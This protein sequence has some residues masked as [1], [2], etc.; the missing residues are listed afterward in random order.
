MVRDTQHELIRQVARA[1]V[2]LQRLVRTDVH[3]MLRCILQGLA[4]RAHVLQAHVQALAGERMRRVRRVADKHGAAL[5]TPARGAARRQGQRRERRCERRRERAWVLQTAADVAASMLE[6]QRETRDATRVDGIAPGRHRPGKGAGRR[7]ALLI[8]RHDAQDALLQRRGRRR[9]H[10]VQDRLEERPWQTERS[11]YERRKHARRA[12]CMHGRGSMHRHDRITQLGRQ[13][14]H[15]RAGGRRERE[16]REGACR[17]EPLPCHRVD[18]RLR[19]AR[20]QTRAQRRHEAL[21]S[22]GPSVALYAR[23]GP[24]RRA[25]AIRAHQQ[26]RAHHMLARLVLKRNAGPVVGRISLDACDFR[27]A[28]QREAH[29]AVR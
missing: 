12:V 1:F 20:V 17:H 3:A 19:A 11:R 14:P 21:A 24:H 5:S 25:R 27:G 18:H 6:L 10:G 23:K 15:D 4:Q 2:G 26:A 13:G 8:R 29:A 7:A 28:L 16:A 22:I 9:A